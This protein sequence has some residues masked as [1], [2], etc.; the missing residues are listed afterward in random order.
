[1]VMMALATEVTY[2]SPGHC[3]S[4]KEPVSEDFL[5]GRANQKISLL[6]ELCI[7]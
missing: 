6:W 5:Q 7:F 3:K 2:L 1:M 4:I